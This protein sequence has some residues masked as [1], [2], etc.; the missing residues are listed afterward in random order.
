MQIVI[1]KVPV[2]MEADTGTFASLLNLRKWKYFN[3]LSAK[4][5]KWSNSLKQTLSALADKFWLSTRL[6]GNFV[7]LARERLRKRTVISDARIFYPQEVNRRCNFNIMDSIYD[8]F[9]SL[10]MLI[11]QIFEGEKY[12]QNIFELGELVWS[13]WCKSSNNKLFQSSA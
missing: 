2:K 9:L 8:I 12:K 11:D 10:P 5:T 4:P 7:E 3:P 1:T 13:V 6:F